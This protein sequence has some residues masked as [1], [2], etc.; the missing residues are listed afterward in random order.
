MDSGLLQIVEVDIFM[1]LLQ[2][3]EC[4]LFCSKFMK[5]KE[6]SGTGTACFI[7]VM[8]PCETNRFENFQ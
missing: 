3:R 8:K 5:M 1:N 4:S 6:D 2:K 7:L